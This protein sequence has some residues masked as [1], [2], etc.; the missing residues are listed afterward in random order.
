MTSI[1]TSI[2]HVV[3]MFVQIL[4]IGD[5]QHMATFKVIT[6]GDGNEQSPKTWHI[7]YGLIFKLKDSKDS[8]LSN[9]LSQN[10]YI[11]N[12]KKEANK[13][14]FLSYGRYISVTLSK[15]SE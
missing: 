13:N 3:R 9:S 8:N 12:Q 7:P 10:K 14:S 15:I 11:P 1:L 2:K 6:L 4:F 5:L